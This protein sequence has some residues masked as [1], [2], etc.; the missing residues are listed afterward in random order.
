MRVLPCAGTLTRMSFAATTLHLV[1]AGVLALAAAERPDTDRIL[2]A[3]RESLGGDARLAGVTTFS[4]TGR[5]RQLRGN[6][7]VPI[8]FEVIVAFPDRYVRTEEFPAQD[9]DP[10]TQG[11]SGDVLIQSPVSQGQLAAI[12]QDFARLTLALFACSFQG[13]P[14]A[15]SYLSEADAPEGKADV[16]AV[17]GPDNF[18]AELVIQRDSHLPVM[19]MWRAAGRGLQPAMETRLYY[20][21]F[22]DVDGL[23]WPFRIRRAVAGQTVEETTFDRYRI[24]P[25]IDPKKFGGAK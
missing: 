24:N 7:L 9:K 19:L 5:T 3:A 21:D 14:L 4:A 16:L 22:R 25:R 13:Y 10:V 1:M 20:G 18:S 6:N 15:F 17:S 8:E 12:K 11:F 23:K 2:R